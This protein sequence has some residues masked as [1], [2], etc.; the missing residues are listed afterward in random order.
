MYKLNNILKAGQY[1]NMYKLNNILLGQIGQRRNQKEIKAYHKTNKKTEKTNIWDFTKAV[2]RGEC[3][4]INYYI[5]KKE[6]PQTNYLTLHFIERRKQEQ[7]TL[8]VRRRKEKMTVSAETNETGTRK[9]MEKI[10]TTKG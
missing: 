3:R 10:N 6:S 4:G 9:T 7:N 2:L 1:M 8:K 5:K